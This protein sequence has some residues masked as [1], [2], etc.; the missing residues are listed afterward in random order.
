MR[1]LLAPV[2]VAPVFLATLLS[3]VAG[4]VACGGGGGSTGPTGAENLPGT[5]TTAH[6]PPVAIAPMKLVLDKDGKTGLEV[7]A[8]GSIVTGDGVLIASFDGRKLVGTH[9]GKGIVIGD[10][11]AMHPM[12]GGDTDGTTLAFDA[13]GDIVSSDGHKIAVA[14]DGSIQMTDATKGTSTIPAHVV[15]VTPTTHRLAALLV[16]V[17]LMA[18][19]NATESSTSVSPPTAVPPPPPP[20]PPPAP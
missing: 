11:G 12:E 17:A 19:R 13:A 3:F 1:K 2:F 16:F 4:G 14:D 7:R 10:D 15:G 9:S 8:D 5:G 18:H 6:A 20:P